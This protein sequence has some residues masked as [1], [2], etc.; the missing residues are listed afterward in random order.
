MY[1]VSRKAVVRVLLFSICATV[2]WNLLSFYWIMEARSP[3]QIHVYFA[4]VDGDI[5]LVGRENIPQKMTK[6]S[7]R[8]EN[9]T[10]PSNRVENA[11]RPKICDNCFHTDFEYIL[12]SD[13]CN[14]NH[15]E[16]NVSILLLVF[17]KHENVN[18]RK[19]L[20]RTW[21][22]KA[23]GNITYIFVFGKSEMAEL[24]YNIAD[25][26]RLYNDILL[27]NF[28]E[29]YR[30]LTLKTISAFKWAVSYCSHVNYVMKV[31]DDM[32][33]NLEALQE[34]VTTPMGLS[35]NKLFGSCSKN[36]RPFRESSH[37]YYVP[38][39]MY[40]E[41]TYPPYCSGTGYLTHM[42][43]IRDIVKLSPNIPFFPLEDIYIALCLQQLGFNVHNMMPFHSYKVYPHPCLYRSSIVITSHGITANELK[44]IWKGN[45]KAQIR[46]W[47]EMGMGEKGGAT[48]P[49]K[50][51]EK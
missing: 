13:V 6:S 20:R 22:S 26:Q 19:A 47:Q 25:E 41:S 35:T 42:N 33:V 23:K 39:S 10:G 15:T 8:K 21:L 24:N 38:Y 11:T 2:I 31:D 4:K 3:K 12:Q 27:I 5:I 43:L 44:L 30:N 37:K 36:A 9:V 50:Q 18:Q 17:S 7:T 45:C 51:I 49:L 14:R 32:W 16:E 1:A 48:V 46:A 29:N 34:F 28:T 40:P